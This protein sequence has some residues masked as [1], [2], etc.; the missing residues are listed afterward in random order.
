M[1]GSAS[2][3]MG[4]SEPKGPALCPPPMFLSTRHGSRALTSSPAQTCLSAA[5]SLRHNLPPPC[6]C[7]FRRFS[8]VRLFGTPRLQP[9]RLL[10]SW[11]SPG[12]NTRVGRHA[13]FQGLFPTQGLNPPLLPLLPW[14]E[15]P[16]PL[17]PPRK[18]PP[19]DASNSPQ[20]HLFQEI[21]RRVSSLNCWR[22][23][24]NFLIA[25]LYS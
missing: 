13:L 9:T 17:V 8:H 1:L 24:Y 14:Q 19:W 4:T 2:C 20:R 11:D 18:P 25:R 7:V 21:P 6:M 3:S 16:S 15:G 10:C 12:K 5:E 23:H 22:I